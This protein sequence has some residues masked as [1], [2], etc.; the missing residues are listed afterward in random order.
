MRRITFIGVVLIGWICATGAVRAAEVYFDGGIKLWYAEPKLADRA[1]M[2]GPSGVISIDETYWLRAYYLYGQF[3]Y[4]QR[5]EP[6]RVGD[7]GVYDAEL[8]GGINWNIFHFGVGLHWATVLF[9]ETGPDTR[10]IRNKGG[11]GPVLV[12]GVAQSLTEWPWGFAGS[13]WGW[14]SGATWMF[15]DFE[16]HNGEY[17]N[18]EVGVTHMSHGLYKSIGYRFKETFEHERMEGFTA[19]LLFEF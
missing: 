4:I 8:A 9:E 14:Y 10:T 18:F 13:P 7:F 1:M 3:D 16:D 5:R 11:F 19:T 17:I 15:H 2:Y 12:A 6:R